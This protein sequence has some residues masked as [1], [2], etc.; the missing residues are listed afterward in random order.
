MPHAIGVG[1]YRVRAGKGWIAGPIMLVLLAVDIVEG[2]AQRSW[3]WAALYGVA[4]VSSVIGVAAC[5]QIRQR[6][7]RGE[8]SSDPGQITTSVD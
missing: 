1:A 8:T 2:M 6:L 4:F 7:Q 5:W 3:L